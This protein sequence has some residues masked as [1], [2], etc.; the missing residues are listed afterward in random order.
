VHCNLRPPEITPLV[1]SCIWPILYFA[2]AKTVISDIAVRF[3][4]PDFIKKKNN[5]VI[6]RR[7]YAVTLTSDHLTLIVISTSVS[8][9]KRL[10][11]IWTK[12]NNPGMRCWS[13]SKFSCVCMILWPWSLMHLTSKFCSTS[14]VMC[15]VSNSVQI[16]SEIEQ[17]VAELLAI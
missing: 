15:S 8:R 13:F 5:L 9:D 7:F 17:S 4:D 11:Q 6:R 10:Y 1:L 14:R 3:R 16:L 2:C 12:S